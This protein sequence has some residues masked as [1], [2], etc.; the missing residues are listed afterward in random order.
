MFNRA[1]N[2]VIIPP[3]HW[4]WNGGILDSPRCLSVH[5]SV[6]PSICRQGFWNFLKKLLAQL[7]SYLA[8]TLMRWVSW[9]LFIFVFL[10]SFLAVWWPNIW[11]KMGFLEKT[12]GPIHFI[13]GIYPYGVSWPL[14]IFVFLASFSALWWPNIWAKMGFPELFEIFFGSIHFIPGIY[15]YGMSL[16]TPIHLHV[17]GLIFGPLVAK[18]LA[19]NGVSRTG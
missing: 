3:L 7:I 17:P 6:H 1:V 8:L 13:P 14:Y 9:P 18:Y 5:L 16:L 15:L 4:R 12:F 11:P 10:A 2:W 19:R